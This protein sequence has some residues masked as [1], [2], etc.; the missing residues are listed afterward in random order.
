M[1]IVLKEEQRA[2]FRADIA[3]HRASSPYNDADYARLVLRVSLNTYKKCVGS[4]DAL[5]LKTRVYRSIV[6][7]IGLDH[8]TYKVGVSLAAQAPEFGSYSRADFGYLVGRYLLYRRSFQDGIAISRAVL[9]I[10]WNDQLSCLS[11]I[12]MRRYKVDGGAWQANDIKGNIH[13]HAERVLMG[14]LAIDNGDARLTLLHIPSRL[15][16]G[17]T[18]GTIRSSG[19]VITHGYPKRFFQPVVSPVT[20]EA[21]GPT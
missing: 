6:G 3:R 5:T 16:I 10:D 11:F 21:I 4:G 1:D 20:I 2:Q 8:A 19:V 9:D 13:I 15:T 7:N 12:E 18:M 14:L 17:T